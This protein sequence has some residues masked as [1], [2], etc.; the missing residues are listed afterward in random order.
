MFYSWADQLRAISFSVAG[1]ILLN[2]SVAD[3]VF[4]DTEDP[5]LGLPSIVVPEHSELSKSI[6]KL[7]EKLFFD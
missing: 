5:G 6:V 3:I 1:I 4:P 2:F 7:G